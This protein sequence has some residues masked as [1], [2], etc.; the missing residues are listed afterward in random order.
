M[1]DP[2]YV[3]G[4]TLLA[5]RELSEAQLRARLA[6]RGYAAA[7]IDQA[8]ARLKSERALD[9]ERAAGAIA[10]TQLHVR[11]R[12][13]LR[14]RRQIEAA[15][16][17]PSIAERAVDEAFRDV[18]PD[19]LLAAA[20]DK[21]LRGRTTLTENEFVRLYRQLVGQGFEAERVLAVLRAQVRMS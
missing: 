2:A 8:V 9:D 15:G 6:R 19:T 10:R 18:D 21:R 4:L 5:R 16:I 14:V 13:H 17:A 1:P 7:A 12:G 20:V 3:T 11:G